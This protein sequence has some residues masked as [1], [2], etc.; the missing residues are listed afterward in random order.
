MNVLTTV[1]LFGFLIVPAVWVYAGIKTTNA[2]KRRRRTDLENW[3][4]EKRLEIRFADDQTVHIQGQFDSTPLAIDHLILGTGKSKTRITRIRLTRPNQQPTSPDRFILSRRHK[5]PSFDDLTGLALT[6]TGDT[7]LDQTFEAYLPAGATAPWSTDIVRN[8]IGDIDKIE[9]FAL[10]RMDRN[11]QEVTIVLRNH[12]DIPV[13]LD[14]CLML[15][16][17]FID[18]RNKQKYQMPLSAPLVWKRPPEVTTDDRVST[19]LG[20]AIVFGFILG[21]VGTFLNPAMPYL[22]TP[23]LCEDGQKAKIQSRSNGRRSS[24]EVV[25]VDKA[26][27]S[28]TI[29]GWASLFSVEV[30]FVGIALIAFVLNERSARKQGLPHSFNNNSV[31][32]AKTK[33][34]KC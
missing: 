7:V 24:S 27:R 32:V 10:M 34:F 11:A 12:L 15:A 3:A 2:A 4:R 25:C 33:R 29:S 5:V 22:M 13:I 17:T 16:S 19:P 18:P 28:E 6:P 1:G 26:G 21:M 14:R 20:M 8:T 23:V 9:S 31:T 30:H